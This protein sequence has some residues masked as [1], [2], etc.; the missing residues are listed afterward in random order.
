M[1]EILELF[2]NVLQIVNN[3]TKYEI[4]HL[5]NVWIIWKWKIKFISDFKRVFGQTNNFWQNKGI[6]ENFPQRD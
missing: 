5:V 3:N 4:F 1:V 6:F 2:W